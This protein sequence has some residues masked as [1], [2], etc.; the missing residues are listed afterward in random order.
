MTP[1]VMPNVS[2]HVAMDTTIV[3]EVPFEDRQAVE[4][5]V[6][7]AFRWFDEVE[8]VCSRFDSKSELSRL[9]AARPGTGVVVSDLLFNILHFSVQ[10]AA[11]SGDGFDPTV[12]GAMARAGFDRNFRTGER[13]SLAGVSDASFRDIVLTPAANV[14]TLLRPVMLD[15]G[16]VAKGFAIDLAAREL[17]SFSSFAINAGGDVFVRGTNSEGK[18]WKIG[19]RDPRDFDTLAATL[20]VTNSAVCTSGDY[21][22]RTLNGTGHILVPQTGL[23][24]QNAAS[25]T[26][27]A[28]TAMVADALAT[29]AFVLGPVRGIAFLEDQSV[30]GLIIS[31]AGERYETHG[32]PR[33]ES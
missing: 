29:A 7:A 20:E 24:A 22:R 5:Q 15:L 14:V 32:L 1:S 23:G 18:P 13:S 16:A 10:V 17:S 19:V 6:R 33:F 31:A 21:E 8:R 11:A 30:E 12:G 2:Y 4:R 9:C 25:V 26:V 28:P 3:I 27:I